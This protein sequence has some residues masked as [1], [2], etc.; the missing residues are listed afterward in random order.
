MKKLC[1]I[2]V[3]ASAVLL[4]AQGRQQTMIEWPY[5][6]GE[7]SHTKYST[8][9]DITPANV[10]QLELA[11]QWQH[12]DVPLEEHR[13]RPGNFE[14]TPLMIDNVLYVSTPYNLVVALNG[15]TGAELW[16]FDPKSYIDGQASAII[17]THFGRA[18]TARGRNASHPRHLHLVCRSSYG[19]GP[20][21]VR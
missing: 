7:Q 17:R 2:A 21:A 3:V 5:F 11:W 16:V 20:R 8:A 4:S 10:N 18:S 14:N 1:A 6:G 12:G 15:E 19:V 13:T 9:A